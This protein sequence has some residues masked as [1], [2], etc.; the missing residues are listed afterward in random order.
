MSNGQVNL[1][2]V[3]AGILLFSITLFR[4]EWFYQH[5]I[6]IHVFVGL[7]IT[8]LLLMFFGFWRLIGFKGW[9]GVLVLVGLEVGLGLFFYTITT[10]QVHRIPGELKHFLSL[11]YNRGFMNSVQFDSSVS[12]FDSQLQYLFR[13]GTYDFNNSEFKSVLNINSKGLR[14]SEAFLDHPEVVFLG[15]SYTM[16]WGV[17]QEESFEALFEE[18]MEIACLNAGVSS[19]GTARERLLM[20]RLRLDSCKVIFIQYCSNDLVENYMFARNGHELAPES[21]LRGG[22]EL[23]CRMNTLFKNYYPFKHVYWVFRGMSIYSGFANWLATVQAQERGEEEESVGDD[24]GVYLSVI[25]KSIREKFDGEI[26]F[27]LLDAAFPDELNNQLESAVSEPGLDI[28]W[29]DMSKIGLTP[30][31]Y[32]LLDPHI[33]VSGHRKVADALMSFVKEKGILSGLN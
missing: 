3:M 22:Y 10:L 5:E 30:T 24:H 18:E 33:N 19:Y 29:L 20:D 25:L 6:S 21:E 31:D 1:I 28:H 11:A 15:D 7:V 8:G 32:F 26:V 23:Y 27:F 9:Y 14:E 16:G 2:C 4:Q 17:E 13:P 12:Q